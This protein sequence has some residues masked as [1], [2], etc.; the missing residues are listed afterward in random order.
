MLYMVFFLGVF[1]CTMYVQESIQVRKGNKTHRTG[2]T[3]GRVLPC[4]C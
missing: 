2:V 3:D 1:L 4:W